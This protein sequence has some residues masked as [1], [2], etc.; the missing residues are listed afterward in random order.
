[1]FK[2]AESAKTVNRTQFQ[3][4][5][6]FCALN[7]KAIAIVAV[8]NSSRFSRDC[9]TPLTAS[10]STGRRGGKYP[11]YHCR[12]QACRSINL[13]R[14]DLHHKFMDLLE[15]LKPNK[16]FW[17][18][19]RHVLLDVWKAKQTT[20]VESAEAAKKRIQVLEDRK[21][22]LIDVL[23]D[24]KLKQQHFDEQ[25]ERLESD[26]AK[27]QSQNLEPLPEESEMS[28]LIAFAEWFFDYAATVWFGAEYD[29]KLRLQA[30][31]FPAGLEVSKDG[32]GTPASCKFF[33]GIQEL[34]ADG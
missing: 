28:Q 8:Y 5:L 23:L 4:M 24:G 1:M 34:D 25:M 17:P 33:N 7:H 10:F 32:F 2:E 6:E 12:K 18:L 19:F 27:A 16:E 31:L 30:A 26:L 3:D 14:D 21:Q 22:K 15:S 9:S 29:K 11:Y 20:R 13:K